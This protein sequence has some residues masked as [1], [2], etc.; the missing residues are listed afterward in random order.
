MHNPYQTYQERAAQTASPGHLLL[1]LFDGALRFSKE[2]ILAIE[3]GDIPVSH[4]KIN[5]VQ[6]I[7]N[8]LIITLDRE[9]GGELA[10][11]LLLLYEY[12]TRRLI[13]ANV[14]K[15]SEILKE[16]IGLLQELREGFAGAA[17]QQ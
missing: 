13:E 9:Q 16:V 12:I 11:N 4:A 10:E 6:D 8:E 2:G 17:R 7:I 5:R 15:N 3:K 14:S 1:M